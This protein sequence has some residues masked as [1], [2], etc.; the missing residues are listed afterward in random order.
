MGAPKPSLGYPSRTAAVLA[1]RDQGL[2]DRVIASRIGISVSTVAALGCARPKAVGRQTGPCVTI[3]IKG[4]LA[5]AIID[6]AAARERT[7]EQLVANLV[8]A[9]LADDMFDAVLDEDAFA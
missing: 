5:E 4:N 8:A 2:C 1:L 6:E 7:A 9:I 3:Q